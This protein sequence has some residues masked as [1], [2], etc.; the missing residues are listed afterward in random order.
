[1]TS[2]HQT[3]QAEKIRKEVAKVDSHQHASLPPRSMVH[4][5]K[6]NTMKFPLIRLL[7]LLFF[8]IIILVATAPYWI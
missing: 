1:M 6:H 3:D 8:I 7:L 4:K 2:K 5:K